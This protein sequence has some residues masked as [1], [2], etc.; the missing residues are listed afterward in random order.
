MTLININSIPSPGTYVFES[1]SGYVPFAFADH[2]CCYMVG[3]SATGSIN[4]PTL[5]ISADDF[6]NQ[7]GV[8]PSLP[9][10]KLFF[11]NDPS[12]RLFFVRA[13]AA[14]AN[15][16]TRAEFL[17]AINNALQPED[18]Q[19]FL[20]CPQA[21]AQLSS[22]ADKLAISVA[23][24]DVAENED[25]NWVALIDASLGSTTVA[26]LETEFEDVTSARGNVAVFAPWLVTVD[27]VQV[28]PSAAVAGLACRRFRIEGFY[29]PPAGITY[30]LRGVTG[31]VKEFSKIEQDVLNPQGINLVRRLRNA[32]VVVWGSRTKTAN[33][34]FRFI[35][36]RVTFNV[37]ARTL[38]DAFDGLIFYAVDGQGLLFLRIK[39]T[40]TQVMYRVW[41]AGGLYG[42]TPDEAFLVVCDESNNPAIDLENG[43]VRVD[44]FG[45]P[46]PTLERLVNNLVR[47]PIGS[48]SVLT[49]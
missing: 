43:I 13:T 3:T 45:S 30:A 7:F 41:Q 44:L 11:A 37:I 24:K 39:E 42:R 34:Y 8:S 32:G 5:V 22:A 18:Q 15:E 17:A 40:A 20:I 6:T 29:Q 35:N 16:P 1:T 48:I 33:Q 23:M 26:S 21:F 19:G 10:V 2:A 36:Q 25:Y 31:L 14:N 4:T 47:V 9:Y 46:S 49:S 28:P 27:N 38:K 12:G